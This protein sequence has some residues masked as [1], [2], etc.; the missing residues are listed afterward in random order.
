MHWP[1]HMSRT[2]LITTCVLIGCHVANSRIC[3]EVDIRNNLGEFETKL[4]NCTTIAGSLTIALIH[5]HRNYDY[6]HITFPELR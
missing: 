6:S 2:L 1:I 3:D 5:K 4:R